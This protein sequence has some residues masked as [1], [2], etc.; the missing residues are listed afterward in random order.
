M[1]TSCDVNATPLRLKNVCIYD[2][3]EQFTRFYSDSTLLEGKIICLVSWSDKEAMCTDEHNSKS[4]SVSGRRKGTHIL[5]IDAR[6]R[7]SHVSPQVA[8]FINHPLNYIYISSKLC[9]PTLFI[10]RRGHFLLLRYQQQNAIIARATS[11]KSCEQSKWASSKTIS[12]IYWVLWNHF[13]RV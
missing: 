10:Q 12:D 3:Y 7:H 5:I 9:K 2:V 4:Y 13:N 6:R 8:N 11:A 1:S